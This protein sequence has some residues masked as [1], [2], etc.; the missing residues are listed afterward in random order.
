MKPYMLDVNRPNPHLPHNAVELESPPPA[1]AADDA[2][3]ARNAELMIGEI[4]REEAK[5]V[6]DAPPREAP[7]P[8]LVLRRAETPDETGALCYTPRRVDMPQ[9]APSHHTLQSREVELAE[10]E[11]VSEVFREA[12]PFPQ[13]GEAG[14]R[15]WLR[16]GPAH[17]AAFVVGLLVVFW[18]A[19][20]LAL[21]LL[22]CWLTLAA[23]LLLTSPR[24]APVAQR[25]W[26]GYAKRRPEAAE[27]LRRGADA[28]AVK[29]DAAL[30]HLPE[31]WAESLSLPDFSQPVAQQ[32]PERRR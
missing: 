1:D 20:A 13:E 30:D 27:R 16:I 3:A 22:A 31:S 12:E 6:P 24:F 18:P 32:R 29:Y 14:A 25:L 19:L 10:I 21:G 28:A 11:R 15:G 26:R 4:M 8:R 9:A 7:R 23:F 2:L 5:E 17:A